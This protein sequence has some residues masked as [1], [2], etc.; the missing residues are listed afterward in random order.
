MLSSGTDTDFQHDG[1]AQFCARIVLHAGCLRRV[2]HLAV[3]WL[4]AC[5]AVGA[6]GGWCTGALFE[7]ICLR[8]VHKFGHVA[9]LLITFGL[10]YVILELVQLIWGRIA[11]EFRPPEVLQAG[12]HADQPLGPGLSVVGAAPPESC[13]AADTPSRL[14]VHRFR[15]PVV[16]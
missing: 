8:R 11:L 4:L 6:I 14:P 12:L 2:H 3:G 10:S 1:R 16:S 7:R 13:A 9:E 15:R 5:L